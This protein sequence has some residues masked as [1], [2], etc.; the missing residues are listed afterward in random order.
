MLHAVDD[1]KNWANQPLPCSQIGGKQGAQD[2]QDPKPGQRHT[3]RAFV[4]CLPGT[5]NII[6]IFPALQRAPNCLFSRNKQQPQ[7]LP[8]V[9]IKYR[10]L[11]I[12]QGALTCPDSTK[13]PRKDRYDAE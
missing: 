13:G 1:G 2:L 6:H 5:V 8:I 4:S 10:D 11:A 12:H 9:V 7:F 3:L